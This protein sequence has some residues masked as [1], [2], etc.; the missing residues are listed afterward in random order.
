MRHFAVAAVLAAAVTGPLVSTAT[1][2]SAAAPAVTVTAAEHGKPAKPAKPVR[3]QFSAVGTVVAVDSGAG[4]ITVAARAGTKDVKGTT[5]TIAVPATARITINGARKRLADLAAGY[6]VT[7]TGT[8]T[9]TA[10]T[11]ARVQA[12]KARPAP[13]PSPSG[14]ATPEPGDDNTHAA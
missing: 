10:Y 9:G 3:S 7:V 12:T 14:S 6:R 11:A 1:I 5:V 2:A 4:T 13:A 8:R